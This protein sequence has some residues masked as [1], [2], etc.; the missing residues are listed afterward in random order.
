MSHKDFLPIKLMTLPARSREGSGGHLAMRLRNG[1][2]LI[3]L[4][5]VLAILA[6]VASFGVPGFRTL[7]QNNNMTSQAN[8]MLGLLQMAR[9]EAVTRRQ[10][11]TV[12]PSSDHSTCNSADWNDGGLARRN[13]GTVIRV[14]PAGTNISIFGSAVIAYAADGTSAGG[15]LRVCDS[16][17]DGN[18]RT[19]NVNAVGQAN[20]RRYQG[21]DV[22]CPS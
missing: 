22:A 19:I 1:F 12:C 14:M 20:N 4:M 5:V 9:S 7:I 3:E 2:T 10:P 21:G 15:V 16:R 6:L 13:D 11:V 17:G 18:S 8:G